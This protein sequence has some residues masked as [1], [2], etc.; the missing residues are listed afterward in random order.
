MYNFWVKNV[1]FT[2][3]S[4]HFRSHFSQRNQKFSINLDFSI[5]ECSIYCEKSLAL[6]Y[7]QLRGLNREQIVI[8]S[9]K[10]QS[11][12]YFEKINIF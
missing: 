6:R 9:R 11:Q 2:R 5:Y 12:F 3:K 4:I 8:F 10:F 1:I 7:K